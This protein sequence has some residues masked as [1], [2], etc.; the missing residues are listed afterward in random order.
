MHKG[1]LRA[2]YHAY[3]SALIDLDSPL[4]VLI[5]AHIPQSK[6]HLLLKFSSAVF[7]VV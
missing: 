5:H 2:L 7:Q 4:A 1:H 3:S 6:S